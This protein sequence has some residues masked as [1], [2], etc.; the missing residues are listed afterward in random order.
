MFMHNLFTQFKRSSEAYLTAV[1]LL[2]IVILGVL[3]PDFLT[4]NNWVD[5][6][7]SYSVTA[8]LAIGLFVVLVTGGID[9]SFA[10][11]ASVAQYVAAYCAARLNLPAPVV[12]LVGATIGTLL[13]CFNALL[14]DRLRATAIIITISTMSVYFAL[15][16]YFTSGKSIYG[17][18]A[19]WSDSMVLFEWATGP[20][21]SVRLTLPIVV[22]VLV[23]VV[24]AFIMNRTS[25]GRQLYAMGGNPEAAR[26][27]GVSISSM[28]WFAYGYLG[29]LAGIAGLLQAHRVGE[30]VPNAM[31]GSELNVI[32]A[33]VLGGASL[34]GGIGSVSGVVLGILLLAILRNGLNLLGVSPYFFQIVIGVILLASTGI[35]GLSL[36][37]RRVAEVS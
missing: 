35:T 7:E 26:R 32:A 10:A 37:R 31:I 16:M 27:V 33:A 3:T 29:L 4:L 36:R 12:L 28:Q 17:L 11:T 18:P 21:E 5:L 8:I 9:I 34:M 20:D 23:A 25:L 19:W 14:I 1:I 22:M 24:T 13:G 6:I 30:S 2:I 15:L